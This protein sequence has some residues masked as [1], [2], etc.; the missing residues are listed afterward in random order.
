MSNQTAKEQVQSWDK[1]LD[2]YE[3][4]I[5]LPKYSPTL[6]PEEELNTYLTMDR[7]ALEKLG[8]EDCA[9]ISYR[10]GQYS[11]HLQRTVNREL[12]RLNWAEEKIKEVLIRLDLE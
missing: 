7:N 6:L 10:L 8:P 9:Q 5:G 1:I 3:Q 2:E 11:F 12:A 4:S